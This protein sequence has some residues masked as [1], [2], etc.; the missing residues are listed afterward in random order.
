MINIKPFLHGLLTY[1]PGML[2]RDAGATVSARYCYSVWLRHL[3]KLDEAGVSTRPGVV[4][5]LGP[6]ASLGVGLAA[7]ISGAGKYYAFDEIKYANSVKNLE[8]FEELVE[9]FNR[10]ER[11][12]DREEFPRV[13]P[14]LNSYDFPHHILSKDRL[15]EVLEKERLEAI[16]QSIKNLDGIS[17]KNSC[18]EYF[19]PWHSSDIVKDQSVDMILSQAVLEHVKDVE[20]TYDAIYRWL[21]Y[22][23]VMSHVID[24]RSHSVL[25]EW[26]GHW[27][28]S[29]FAWRL[30]KGRRK[31]FLN[32]L[33]YSAHERFLKEAGFEIINSAEVLK[34]SRIE[35]GQLALKFIALTDRDLSIALAFIQAIKK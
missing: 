10:Q 13:W 32:R 25:R 19:A 1:L 34:E 33:P 8:I 18:I 23:G 29:D 12:P 22:G 31:Y 2:P 11:I 7:L 26:N 9:L 3:V 21:K 20:A 4:A 5:E 6:G 30:I 35:R 14:Q 17:V 24:F 15:K 27:R 28:Y 16:R